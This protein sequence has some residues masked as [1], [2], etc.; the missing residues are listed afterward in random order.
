MTDRYRV[1]M[2]FY[3][4][5]EDAEDARQQVENGISADLAS[6]YDWQDTEKVNT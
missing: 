5:A 1:E 2:A 6:D 4:Y 3:R